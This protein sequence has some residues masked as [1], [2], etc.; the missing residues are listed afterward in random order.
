MA[1]GGIYVDAV[2]EIGKNPASKH[3]IQESEQADA[4]RDGRTC[5]AR[6]YS[7]VSNGNRETHSFSFFS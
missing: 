7:Q 5:L 1:R 4:G 3:Q 6:P 2:A